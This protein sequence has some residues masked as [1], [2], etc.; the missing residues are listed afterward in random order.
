MP[1]SA[2]RGRSVRKLKVCLKVSASFF[3]SLIFLFPQ[4]SSALSADQHNAIDSGARYVNTEDSCAT[5][6]EADT[7]DIKP[8]GGSFD[9]NVDVVFQYLTSKGLTPNQAI[10]L[11]INLNWESGKTM[12]PK[13]VQGGGTSET[14]PNDSKTGY[15]IAQWT[16]TDRKRGLIN[17]A[18][19]LNMN[20]YD[21]N[22]QAR[23][24][25]REL[26]TNSN[27]GLSDLKKA[28]SYQ[29]AAQVVIH[30]F[31]RPLAENTA[32]RI[33]D[34]NAQKIINKYKD[35]T[36]SGP[37]STP[38]TL[39][40]SCVC[41]TQSNAVDTG[42]V[43]VLDP[44]HSQDKV[45]KDAQTG[46]NDVDSSNTATGER[47]DVWD[48]AKIAKNKLEDDGY[49]VILT[50]TNQEDYS[51]MRDRAT[52]AD[53]AK[54]DIAV[55]IHGDPGLG[56]DGEIYEQ[57][58]GL[59]RGSGSDKTVFDNSDLAQK[60]Q[61]YA[62]AFKTAREKAQ[63]GSV[64]I[65]DNSFNGRAPIEP[66]N[67]PLVMLFS[68]TTPW[69]Y[70]ESKMPFDHD[71]YAQGIVDG[72]EKALS[73]STPAAGGTV[74]TTCS[75]AAGNGDA[76]ST[77]FDY[78]YADGRKTLTM[79]DSYALAI[80]KA[81]AKGEYVGGQVYPGIDCGGFITRVMRDSG[82]DKNYN[83]YE[84]PTP[85]QEKY[86]H[87]KPDKYQEIGELNSIDKLQ[88]GDIA[89]NNIHTFMY[90]GPE[91]EHPNFKG[92]AASASLDDYAPTANVTYFVSTPPDGSKVPF[93]WYRLI[94]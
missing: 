14:V 77:A 44:G 12:D 53:Q 62:E 56:N 69:V 26:S 74:D 55:S 82:A 3:L 88:P 60:S 52:V 72:V 4:V 80:N 36:P 73:G 15:G 23:N 87:L 83:S 51:G 63:G 58:N 24:V 32:E 7:A 38:G 35:A 22:L 70:N 11:L 17:Y 81:K 93:T 65:K 9:E 6:Q 91:S 10:G 42:K 75:D 1:P 54:A 71:K 49:K 25:W 61:K 94:K 2:Y 8:S 37:V 89:I 43:V 78:A 46:L 33:N 19:K 48:V 16:T 5:K 66:G 85:V 76:I 59:F 47:Q 31:E 86:M 29:D 13:I 57:K 79:K 34:P 68:K 92:N 50:R 18:N 64:V 41:S 90:V 21:I 20:V 45:V 84:G 39:S 40:G 30:E 27:Y 28:G 67:I